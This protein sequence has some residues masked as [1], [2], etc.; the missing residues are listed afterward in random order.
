MTVSRNER[1]GLPHAP[2][3]DEIERLHQSLTRV[4]GGALTRDYGLS[5][6]EGTELIQQALCA[7][8][9]LTISAADPEAWLISIVCSK[10]E[11]LYRK[12]GGGSA[13]PDAALASS[14]A[15]EVLGLVRGL[16]AL[17][18]DAQK[19]IRLRIREGWSFEDIAA[20]L[21]VTV[22]YARHLVAT[23]LKKLR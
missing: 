12:R 17:P 16:E 8:L 18:A 19:A 21:N 20:E 23:S 22:K 11:E 3:V 2:E 13:V 4:L 6:A 7:Y 15:R 5:A 10:A 9:Q 14:R 1:E